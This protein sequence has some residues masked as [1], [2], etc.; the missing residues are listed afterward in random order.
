MMGNVVKMHFPSNPRISAVSGSINFIC[1]PESRRTFACLFKP[2]PPPI[3][4]EMTGS[5]AS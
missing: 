4:V 2:F 3:L 5:K 1:T